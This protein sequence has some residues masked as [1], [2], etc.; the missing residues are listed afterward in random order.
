MDFMGFPKMARLSRDCI[1]SEK[2]D[3]TNGQIYITE[4]GEFHVG[5][6]NRWITPEDDNYGFARWAYENKEELLKLGPGQHF[7]EYWGQGIARKYNMTEK[8]FSLFNTARWSDPFDRPI[9]CS[10]V[11]VLYQGV[12]D[13]QGIEDI[14]E[15]LR[16]NGSVAAPGFLKP[17]GICIYHTAAARYFKKTVE[18]DEKAKSQVNG[19][20]K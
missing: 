16:S 18:H 1:V 10:V 2:L 7:G 12:F 13:T 11:P 5:S 15:D 17:E 14:I 3:G 4:E 9:C 8:R 19:K 20:G 6:R